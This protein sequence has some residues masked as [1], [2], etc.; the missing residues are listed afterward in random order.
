M[1]EATKISE[2]FYLEELVYPQIFDDMFT[3]SI[4][5]LDMQIVRGLE[6]I[7]THF[8]NKPIRVNDWSSG[9][10]FKYRGL[11][12]LTEPGDW[13]PLKW[14]KRSQHIFGRAVDFNVYGLLDSEVQEE[15]LKNWLK[16]APYF[17]TMEK[18]TV[19][20]THLDRRWLPENIRKLDRPFLVTP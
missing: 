4:W 20:W 10:P 9:G 12:P 16:F 7:R 15:L 6:V 3:S 5:Y 2:H 11:R 18:G 14:S 1:S 19:G 13:A 17:S 8:G